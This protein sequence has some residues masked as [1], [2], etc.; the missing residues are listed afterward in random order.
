VRGDEVEKVR[1]QSKVRSGS[2]WV[3]GKGQEE[4]AMRVRAKTVDGKE[5]RRYENRIRTFARSI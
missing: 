3:A 2:S 1:C 5:A 4:N